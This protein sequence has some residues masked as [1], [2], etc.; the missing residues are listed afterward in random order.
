[1]TIGLSAPI[2]EG[3]S[4]PKV[5]FNV[6]VGEKNFHCIE[7]GLVPED[8]ITCPKEAF[9]IAEITEE[10]VRYSGIGV[11][12]R[13]LVSTGANGFWRNLVV[14]MSQVTKQIAITLVGR[15]AYFSE[16]GDDPKDESIVHDLEL[17]E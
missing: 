6:S 16:L 3:K 8:N 15:R 7:R 17:L 5:G 4:L 2:F 9:Y 12:T 1:L 14:R 11:W 10:L 13:Y